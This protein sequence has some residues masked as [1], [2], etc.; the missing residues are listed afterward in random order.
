MISW[1]YC[2]LKVFSINANKVLFLQRP[3]K[4]YDTKHLK[5]TPAE[6]GANE[7]FTEG[8]MQDPEIQK[9]TGSEILKEDCQRKDVSRG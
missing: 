8:S 1:F 4:K 2:L 9:L 6:I 3:L 7:D 5:E